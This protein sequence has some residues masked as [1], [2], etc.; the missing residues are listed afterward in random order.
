MCEAWILRWLMTVDWQR[1]RAD[2]TT[3]RKSKR[4]QF[5]CRSLQPKRTRTI[6]TIKTTASH[7]LTAICFCPCVYERTVKY[8]PHTPQEHLSQTYEV[9]WMELSSWS[10]CGG[11]CS[12]DLHFGGFRILVVF[13]FF[14][15]AGYDREKTSKK[16]VMFVTKSIYRLHR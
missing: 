10:S 12:R 15:L 1:Y 8:F 11:R 4:E 13:V 2:L 9:R 16:N 14:W 3:V 6:Y 5:W 7:Q